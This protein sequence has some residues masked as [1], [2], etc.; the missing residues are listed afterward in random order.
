VT[1]EEIALH[2]SRPKNNFV[3]LNNYQ[4]FLICVEK[5]VANNDVTQ[6]VRT[7]YFIF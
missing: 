5:V 2:F 6:K 7:I 3:I 4:K 1:V